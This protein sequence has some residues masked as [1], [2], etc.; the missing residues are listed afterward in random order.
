MKKG[1]HRIPSDILA[2]DSPVDH[3]ILF[4]EKKAIELGQPHDDALVIPLP[5]GN[6]QVGRILVDN[7]S[8]ADILFLVAIKEMDIDQSQIPKATTTLVGFIGEST[9]IVGK[10]QLP[11]FIG[12]EN[13]LTTFLVM[14]YPSPYNIIL[15]QP[16]IHS[17]KE[18][19][20]T[21]H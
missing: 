4:H 15:D 21:F 16:W 17:F 14:D 9:S 7:G 20:S 18:V 6:C 13:M 19:P 5:I 10:I 2:G 1:R 11:I 8:S 3:I 12:G